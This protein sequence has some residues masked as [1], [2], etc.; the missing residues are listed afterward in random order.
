MNKFMKSIILIIVAVLTIC[1]GAVM[2]FG[3]YFAASKLPLK[4]YFS[5]KQTNAV[6]D[7]SNINN[8]SD[9]D[10]KEIAD[11]MYMHQLNTVYVDVSD[12]AKI[13]TEPDPQ[14]QTSAMQKLESSLD[15]YIAAMAKRDIK[16]FAAA[17]D[18]SWSDRD[19]QYIPLEI[20]GFAHQFN[21]DHANS[22]LAGAEF[23]IESYNQKDFPTGSDTVKSLVLT[24]YVSMVDKLV[25][26]NLQ[27][28]S[29][30]NT[31]FEVGLAVPYWFDNQNGNIPVITWK[32]KTG[33]VL[34]H[35]MD[36]LNELPKSNIVVMA[37]RNAARGNDGVVAHSRTE[38]DYATAK[39]PKVTV[40]IGQE[41]NEVEP[42]KITYFGQSTEE[43][44]GQFNYV[45][46][47]F[48]NSQQF[49]GIAI[50]DLAGY[51]AM[52]SAE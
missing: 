47:E 25:A 32:N 34:F 40:I 6:W 21:K 41:V 2:A 49:G 27:Y 8:K 5:T 45:V 4:T 50:N 16:V 43:L 44:S 22:K 24:D 28:I 3:M 7:W 23:D 9:S 51:Q 1:I 17:G 52:D 39:A 12:Y 26:K 42:A 37:Y 19:K 15:K 13:I 31:D 18:V 14:K 38:V 29:E 35:V 46:D 33:P 30:T 36:R 10:L 11:F 48:K 20:L